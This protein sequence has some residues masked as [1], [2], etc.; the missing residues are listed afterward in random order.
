MTGSDIC[1]INDGF[2]VLHETRTQIR[3]QTTNCASLREVL[4]DATLLLNN[5]FVT[6]HRS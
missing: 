3:Q 5:A 4:F 1:S 2:E 6:A